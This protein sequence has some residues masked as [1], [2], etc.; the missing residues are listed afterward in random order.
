MSGLEPRTLGLGRDLSL[1]ARALQRQL[2][3]LR[4]LTAAARV[5]L[6]LAPHGLRPLGEHRLAQPLQAAVVVLQHVVLGSPAR[7]AV[8]L[9]E[10]QLLTL[11][12]ERC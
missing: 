10:P 4:D 2:L 12:P 1:G 5:Q 7:E 6:L 9:L 3:L 11:E 8:A